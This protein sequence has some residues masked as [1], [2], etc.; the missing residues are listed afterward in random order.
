MNK[1]FKYSFLL[2]LGACIWG[3]AFVA[4][5]QGMNY[6][7]PFTFNGI[8]NFLGALVLFPFIKILDKNK[9]PE[10]K[11]FFDKTLI[12]GGLVSGVFLFFA[13]SAQ[14]IALKTSDAGKAGFVTALYIILVPIF[15]LLLKKKPGKL[16]FISVIF[17]TIGLYFLCVKEGAGLTLGKEDPYLIACAVLF[18]CQ[19]MAID[20]FAPKVDCVKLSFW[21]FVVSGVMSLVPMAFEHPSMPAILDAWLPIAYA[22]FLSSG[23][24]YTLQVIGQKHVKA[25]VASLVMSLESV[26]SVIFGFLLLHERMTVRETA[27][28][29]IMFAAI[30]F[31]QI[32]P[33]KKEPVKEAVM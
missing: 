11:S 25:S 4:Q 17:A 33:E 23:V 14:Q 29:L 5:R 18:A 6:V 31:A 30:I 10:D 3:A 13:S 32:T 12:I 20:H 22:G 9:A 21:Q 19:I 7:G 26:F 15:S 2:M 8:R 16:I 27:G 1:S 24:A 28:C